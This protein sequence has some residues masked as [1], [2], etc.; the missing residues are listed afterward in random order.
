MHE[1]R[2]LGGLGDRVIPISRDISMLVHC[3]YMFN[4]TLETVTWAAL[5]SGQCL[6]EGGM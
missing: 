5:G 6:N 4:K 3:V 1:A 2:C